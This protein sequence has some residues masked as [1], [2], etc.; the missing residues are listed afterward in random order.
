MVRNS[1]IQFINSNIV[2]TIPTTGATNLTLVTPLEPLS[3][4]RR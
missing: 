1:Q 2:G 3:S 4:L